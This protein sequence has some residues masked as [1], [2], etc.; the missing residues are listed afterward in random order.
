MPN[1]LQ[2]ATNIIKI[3]L[4][5]TELTL[6]RVERSLLW[7][8]LW[9]LSGKT[10]SSLLDIAKIKVQRKFL[11]QNSNHN[12]STY[13]VLESKNE[14][15]IWRKCTILNYSKRNSSTPLKRNVQFFHPPSSRT[16][17]ISDPPHLSTTPL[18]LGWK[19]PYR[20]IKT[21]A[22]AENRFKS[23]CISHTKVI[24]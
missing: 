5:N 2:E 3:C 10:I 24:K 11:D 18:L 16:A 21:P 15:K 7:R 17:K 9:S 13:L 14:S 22:K 12:M 1:F 19:W 6:I 8:W 23:V 4:R 20:L